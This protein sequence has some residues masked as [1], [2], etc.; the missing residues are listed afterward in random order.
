MTKR[1]SLVAILVIGIASLIAIVAIAILIPEPSPFGQMVFKV[2]LALAAACIGAFLPGTFGFDNKVAKGTGA[3]GL[4]VFVFV[5]DPSGIPRERKFDEAMQQGEAA[6]ATAGFN[7]IA[8]QKFREALKMKPDSPLPYS[9]LART[10]FRDGRFASAVESFAK[11]FEL[12]GSKDPSY[13][14]SKANSEMALN[15]FDDAARTFEQAIKLSGSMKDSELAK[16]LAY[17]FAAT[18]FA[19]WRNSAR[20]ADSP[21]YQEAVKNFTLFIESGGF[22]RQWAHY[23]LA[24]MKAMNSANRPVTDPQVKLLR[25]DAATDLR[26]AVHEI[27]VFRGESRPYHVRLIRS[28]LT[29]PQ[30]YKE[31][32][33]DPPGCPLLV[34]IWTRDKGPVATLLAV[35]NE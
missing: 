5:T 25:A 18:R 9:G 20:T 8:E 4:F 1:A 27:S 6:L 10:Y 35:L 24:C 14:Y 28:I 17:D 2:L 16:I 7:R 22:P 33:G 13:L 30:A 29:E 21:H 32:R 34:E 26:S 12:S 19:Q 15:R 23:N 3:M 31:Q 11:A